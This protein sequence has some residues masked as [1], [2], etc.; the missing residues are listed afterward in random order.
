MKKCLVLVFMV[1]NSFIGRTQGKQWYLGDPRKDSV[2]GLS[3]EVAYETLLK[4][5]PST[6]VLV[7]IIDSG[8]DIEHEDL[9]DVIW[10]N[11]KEI[12]GNG[13]DD[14][15]NG[16]VD[17]VHGWNF[18]GGAKGNVGDDSSELTREYARLSKVFEPYTNSTNSKIPRRLKKEYAYYQ[19]IRDKY[20]SQNKENNGK[21]KMYSGV[22]KQ[23]SIGLDSVKKM[24]RKDSITREDLKSI[25]ST[26]PVVLF[27]QMLILNQPEDSSPDEM[28]TGLKEAVDHY[29]GAVK[30]LDTSFDSRAIVGD[31]YNDINERHYGNSDVIGPEPGH[32]THVAGIIAANRKNNIGVKGI[33][34]DVRIMVIRAVPN[35][36][37]RDKDVA[38]AIRYAV[39]NGAR[40]I[41][42]SFGK[43]YSPQ[44]EAV[45]KAVKYAEK[46]G[47]LLVHAAGNDGQDNDKFPNFP[48]P[49]FLNKK[50]AKNWIEVGASGPDINK[51][52]APFSNYGK[53]T[54][55]L[56]SPGVHIYSTLP[57]NKYDF[58]DGTSMA[59]PV[60]VGVA[61]LVMSYFP[62]LTAAE[63]KDILLQSSRKFNHLPSGREDIQGRSF[64]ELSS[65]GG[66][67]NAYEAL[68]LASSKRQALKEK[69]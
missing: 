60:V 36:D 17:D 5:R 47:V 43:G 55:S 37:E 7:A 32:G 23:F 31:N 46:K 51:L 25:K 67:V 61:A 40:I 26:N 68:K 34:N 21:L 42:M 30:G 52:A 56:F 24:L 33:A 22:Y 58:N 8:I 44:K 69:N 35:G 54:V 19:T 11:P 13:Q 66:V 62:Q 4:D 48:S 64:S 14:D 28:K 2:Q 10:T 12:A 65:T 3:T 29:E 39:D 16:Y 50:E 45:D 63:V 27:S 41:N 53:K 59:S 49:V 15:N 38:N 9:K 57:K 6:P 18:I 20:E 1:C